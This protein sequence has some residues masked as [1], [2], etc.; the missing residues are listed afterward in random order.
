LGGQIAHATAQDVLHPLRNPGY[1]ALDVSAL[2]SA[3]AG[4]AARLGAAGKAVSAGGRAGAVAKALAHAPEPRLRTLP[5]GKLEAHPLE[6]RNKALAPLQRA[7]DKRLN[8]KAAAQPE[9]RVGCKTVPRRIG[10]AE[11]GIRV[12]TLQA[13]AH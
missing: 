13:S 2:A 6:S 7:L 10:K 5:S 3:G 1:L 4:T 8:A 12:P 9:G 11:R